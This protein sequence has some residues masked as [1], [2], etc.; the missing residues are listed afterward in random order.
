MKVI[1]QTT[2]KAF[3]WRRLHSIMGLLIVLFLCEHLLTNS[4]AALLIGENGAGFVRAVNFIKNLPYLPVLEIFLIG[5][6][7]AIH[8]VL[9]IKYAITGK[10]NAWPSRG[11]KP[12]LAKYPRNH[13]YSWQRITSWILLVG[14]L[15]HVG[16]MRFYRY[17]DSVHIG[18]KEYYFTRV[19]TD[20]GLSSVARRLDVT[21][22][23]PARIQEDNHPSGFSAEETLIWKKA[24]TKKS[25]KADQV[26]AVS[27]DF[28]TAT[29]LMVRDA[30][31]S[32][33]KGGLYTLFVLAAC[34]H[35]FNGLWTFCITWG[36]VIKARS[37]AKLVNVCTGIMVVIA[38]LGLACIWGTY[39]VNL[40][41]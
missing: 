17:P 24:L 34:F 13:A 26:M 41:K 4:Q 11:E 25:L 19:D 21:L 23:T 35:A 16:Y 32:P 28:G 18:A 6:P 33:I 12:A 31:K 40:P 8:G 37:Q 22:Y 9:G 10:M 20:A 3:L 27:P 15:L 7:I 29:L 5:V 36:W 14:I 30:F 39:F 1:T 38:F 2:S